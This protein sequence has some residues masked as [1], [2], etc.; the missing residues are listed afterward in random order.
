MENFTK[1]KPLQKNNKMK[2]HILKNNSIDEF[3]SRLGISGGLLDRK[4]NQEK[5]HR[6]R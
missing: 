3:S 5:I 6:Q 4:I 2:I 1:I